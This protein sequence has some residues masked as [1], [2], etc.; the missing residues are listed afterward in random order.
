METCNRV[1]GKNWNRIGLDKLLTNLVK[2]KTS[3][4]I[5][6]LRVKSGV[7]GLTLVRLKGRYFEHQM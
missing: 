5:V 1:P 6:Q 3:A 7:I 2:T 4:S